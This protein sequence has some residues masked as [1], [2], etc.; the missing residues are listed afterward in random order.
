MP[1]IFFIPPLLPVLI[2]ILTGI[3][4]GPFGVIR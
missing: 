3:I 4:C 2:K 1:A